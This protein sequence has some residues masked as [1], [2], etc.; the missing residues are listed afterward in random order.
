MAEEEIDV[1]MVWLPLSVVLGIAGFYIFLALYL[2]CR[3]FSGWAIG[4]LRAGRHTNSEPP[5]PAWMPPPEALERREES[6]IQA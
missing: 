4:S 6:T 5:L 1:D 3:L 2:M